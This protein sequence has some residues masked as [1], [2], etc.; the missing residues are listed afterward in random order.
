MDILVNTSV[1]YAGEIKVDDMHDILD[2]KTT[3]G[4]S[5]GNQNGSFG[6]LE[7]TPDF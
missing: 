6:R 7:G 3:S 4:N 5:G 1:H 2:V